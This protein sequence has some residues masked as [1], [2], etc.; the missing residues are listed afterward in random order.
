MR[1][2]DADGQTDWLHVVIM[3]EFQ[4]SVDWFMALRMQRYA[5][6]L[7]DRMWKGRQPTSRD[8]LPPILGVVLYTGKGSWKAATRLSDLVGPGTRPGG[9]AAAA[10]P[11]FAG[12]S[13]FA[14]DLPRCAREGLV[15]ENVVSLLAR[16]VVMRDAREAAAIVTEAYRLLRGP[17]RGELL[18]LF[19]A[20]FRLAAAWLK[21]N[22]EILEDTRRMARLD[23]TGELQPAME[24]FFHPGF[25]ALRAEAAA[26]GAAEAAA[27]ATAEAAARERELLQYL[28][29]RKFGAETAER[30]GTLLATIDDPNRLRTVAGWIID[31]AQGRDLLAHLQGPA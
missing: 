17:E 18:D 2:R 25:E 22:L 15:P 19:L 11:L 20:W 9:E 29:E 7:Y 23:K 30:L 12:E 10:P 16:S 27:K 14:V 31:C 6:R 5:V 1:F 8:R 4:A 13:Y 28:T 3:L 26:E 21:L 24:E